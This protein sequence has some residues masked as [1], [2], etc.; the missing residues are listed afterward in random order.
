MTTE[1]TVSEDFV[2]DFFAHVDAHDF[3]WVEQMLDPECVIQAP[4]FLQKGPEM[5]TIWMAGFFAAFP[6]LT[7]RP[8]RIVTAQ[9][10]VAVELEVTGT[11]T[12]DL[13]QPDG[14]AIPP[15]GR[16]IQ[17]GLAEFW[18]LRDGRVSEY[19]VYYDSFELLTQLGL[20]N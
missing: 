10:E 9:D 3:D 14:S 5:V 7:H 19:R 18:R 20:T 16:T 11:H 6:D 4:G 15:T 13:A 1:T 2:V 12:Q 17:I 8:H